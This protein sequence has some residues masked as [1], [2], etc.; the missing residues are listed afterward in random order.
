MQLKM[1]DNPEVKAGLKV[2]TL[3][4]NPRGPCAI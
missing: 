3:K 1:V 2:E 4:Q